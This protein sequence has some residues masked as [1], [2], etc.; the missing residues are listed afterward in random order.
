MAEVDAQ[1]AKD[2]QEQLNDTLAEKYALERKIQD[3]VESPF[4]K[5]VEKES[6]T[7]KRLA[8]LERQTMDQTD[9]LKRLRERLRVAEDERKELNDQNRLFKS[10]NEKMSKRYEGMGIDMTEMAEMLKSMDPSKFRPDAMEHLRYEGKTPVWAN[11]D[12][13]ERA[14]PLN[15]NDNA[16]LVREIERLQNEK[17]LLASELDKADLLIRQQREIENDLKE[18]HRNEID[19]WNARHRYADREAM[20][21]K[22]ERKALDKQLDELKALLASGKGGGIKFDPAGH[23]GDISVFS[24]DTVQTILGPQDNLIDLLVITAEYDKTGLRRVLQDH[25]VS[26]LETAIST[27]LTIDFFSHEPETTMLVAGLQ[28]QFDVQVSYKDKVDR[29]FIKEVKENAV[30]ITIDVFY[31]LPDKII[32]LGKATI[33]LKNLV[34]EARPGRP[35][36]LHANAPIYAAGASVSI[37]FLNYHLRFREPIYEALSDFEKQT[38]FLE[39]QQAASALTRAGQSELLGDGNTAGARVTLHRATNLQKEGTQPLSTFIAYTFYAKK[40][41]YSS[42]LRGAN[43]SFEDTLTLELTSDEGFRRYLATEKL[44]MLVFD[45]SKPLG[46]GGAGLLGVAEVPLRDLMIGEKK[47][48]EQSYSIVSKEAGIVGNLVVSIELLDPRGADA[49]RFYEGARTSLSADWRKKFLEN[50]AQS[51]REKN[52][53]DMAEA[54]RIFDI[55]SNQKISADEFRNA[56]K[57]MKTLVSEPQIDAFLRDSVIS[58]D[59]MTLEQFS[60]MM[61]PIMNEAITGEEARLLRHFRESC[62]HPHLQLYDAFKYYDFHQDGNVSE[63]EFASVLAQKLNLSSSEIA[64]LWKHLTK[65][66]GQFPYD[67]WWRA[68]IGERS[69]MSE[70]PASHSVSRRTPDIPPRP[71]TE[72]S[73]AP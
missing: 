27:F 20:R 59:G 22:E 67:Q 58:R 39:K 60:A 33:P 16:S 57:R 7:Y 48:F 30:S 71:P 66:T 13:M 56:L 31:P 24:E 42:T 2:I 25:D 9:E 32:Y 72:T 64:L 50:V 45:D 37:G 49:A 12:F 10:Q 65:G 26:Q 5:N 17:A 52:P 19:Q 54:F 41:H 61:E 35:P 46:G 6:S 3:L 8:E 23:D 18:T 70:E 69:K 68:T 4:I 38:E 14:R 21:A 15:L 44:Q 55:D 28:P 40:T 73:H 43:P 36:V 53:Y 1:A 34:E 62:E 29:F 11:M 63:T 51:L 47:L